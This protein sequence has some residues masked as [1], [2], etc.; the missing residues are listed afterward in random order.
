[1]TNTA[2][3]VRTP[4][5]EDK[6]GRSFRFR[7]DTWGDVEA[8]VRDR[9]STARDHTEWVKEAIEARLGYVRCDRAR[10]GQ[11]VPVEW[12]DLTGHSLDWAITEAIAAVRGQKCRDHK[13]VTVGA[14]APAPP[15]SAPGS[16]VF[17]EPGGKPVV[18]AVPE[19][20][21]RKR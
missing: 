19:V 20:P 21:A 16:A 13:P 5:P 3:A 18:A 8:A 9:N 11:A 10:C 2:A 17:M 1:M 15:P 12:G 4:R 6:E 14:Q 7:R